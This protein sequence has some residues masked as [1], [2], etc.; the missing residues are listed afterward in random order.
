[1]SRPIIIDCD[2]GLDDAIALAM[3]LRAPTLD[4]KAV[5]T[6]AGNQTPQKTLHNALGL[7]TLMQR[8]DVLVAGG[9]AKPLMRDLV[10]ADYVHG[11][12]G[13]GNT[14]LPAPDFQPVNKLRSS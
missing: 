2:P 3:A 4:V 1:M 10:I 8:Q 6:S 12:T 14:H 5:T 13:M 7:L 11:D 9:A